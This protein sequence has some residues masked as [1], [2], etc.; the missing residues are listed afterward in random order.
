M[1]GEIWAEAGTEAGT[2]GI[3]KPSSVRPGR[4]RSLASREAENPLSLDFLMMSFLMAGLLPSAGF[5]GQLG[6]PSLVWSAAMSL[7]LFNLSLSS[8]DFSAG[9]S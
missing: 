1:G 6:R 4:G 7:G 2:A 3:R 9:A 5:S 8:V